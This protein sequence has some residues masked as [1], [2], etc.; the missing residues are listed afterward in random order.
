MNVVVLNCLPC[1]KP[2]PP[3]KF[4]RGCLRSMSASTENLKCV[5]RTKASEMERA[6]RVV[7]I[8]VLAIATAAMYAV[9]MRANFLYGYGIGQNPDTKLAIAWANVAADLWKGFGLII[10]VG[11]W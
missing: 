5:A 8:V 9:S 6:V 4:S 1:A 2:S 11:L 10:G 7:V 3:A